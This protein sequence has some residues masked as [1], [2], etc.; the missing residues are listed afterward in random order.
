M[1]VN[2]SHT[3]FLNVL[4]YFDMQKKVKQTQIQNKNTKNVDFFKRCQIQDT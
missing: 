4:L 3:L 1:C 2:K